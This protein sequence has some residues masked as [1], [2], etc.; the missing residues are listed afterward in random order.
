MRF[1]NTVPAI[2]NPEKI[3][4]TKKVSPTQITRPAAERE[5][6]PQVRRHGPPRPM[7]LIDRRKRDRRNTQ[8]NTPL[9]TRTGKDRRKQGDLP[10]DINIK[11]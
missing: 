9:D 8:Y 2:V 1:P 4:D 3:Q 5:D 10:S 7:R 11:A 6:V